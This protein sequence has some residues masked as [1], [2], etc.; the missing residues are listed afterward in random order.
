MFISFAY[1]WQ[2]ADTPLEDTTI[3]SV[4]YSEE[5]AKMIIGERATEIILALKTKDF[6]EFSTYVHLVK[7]VRFSPYAYVD[8]SQNVIFHPEIIRNSLHNAKKYMWGSY[9]GSGFPIEL[10]FDEY[11]KKFIYDQDFANA[12]NISYNRIVGVGNS[13]NN[14]FDAYPNAIVVE[15]HFPGFDPQFE[16]MDW[17]SLRLVFEKEDGTWFLVGIIHDQW[18]I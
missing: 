2:K 14:V 5:E 11:F 15:Y 4:Q 9:D 13:L 1:F 6:P 17:E 18:T 8:I 3:P 10:T 7:G 16:G 12:K